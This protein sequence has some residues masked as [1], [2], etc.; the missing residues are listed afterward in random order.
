MATE[1]GTLK[2]D[3]YTKQKV[4]DAAALALAQENLKRAKMTPAQRKKESASWR[5]L[6]RQ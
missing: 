2:G 1:H 6:R 3:W 5:L 4:K